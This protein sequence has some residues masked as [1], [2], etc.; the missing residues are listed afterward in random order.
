MI[1]ELRPSVKNEANT[2][3]K[4]LLKYAN[5]FEFPSKDYFGKD[6]LALIALK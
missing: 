6:S 5:Y 1:K 4:T 3:N 2:N